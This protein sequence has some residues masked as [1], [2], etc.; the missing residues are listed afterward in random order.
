MAV[1]PSLFQLQCSKMLLVDLL[2]ISVFNDPKNTVILE[3]LS[4]KGKQGR[5]RL[6]DSL[7]GSLI[8]V[9]VFIIKS[10]H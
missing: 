9:F 3:F 6:D 10:A 2:E 7:M 5:P 8:T 4:S 1:V